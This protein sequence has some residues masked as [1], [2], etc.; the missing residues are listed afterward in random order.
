MII[1]SII[2]EI[3]REYESEFVH[4]YELDSGVEQCVADTMNQLVKKD[5]Q[6]AIGKAYFRTEYVTNNKCLSE[7]TIIN[8][9]G[10]VRAAFSS[11]EKIKDDKMKG[12]PLGIM[13]HEPVSGNPRPDHIIKRF[14]KNPDEVM[15][16]YRDAEKN[17]KEVFGLSSESEVKEKAREI[18]GTYKINYKED[19]KKL[20]CAKAYFRAKDAKES[21]SI[22][23]HFV[24]DGET[25]GI[26]NIAPVTIKTNHCAGAFNQ[27]HIA[28]EICEPKRIM[29]GKTDI[30]TL[31]EEE[32]NSKRADCLRSFN[33]AVL[34]SALLCIKFSMDSMGKDTCIEGKN[35][36]YYSTILSHRE[37]HVYFAEASNHGD[38]EAL[39][40]LL[41]Q[42]EEPECSMDK[43]RKKVKE[44]MALLKTLGISEEHIEPPSL[45]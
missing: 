7:P 32:L 44:T 28:I 41:W 23:I 38:P 19:K 39:W 43:F 3:L 25:G 18:R 22:A 40:K 35:K 20:D 13:L 45:P 42:N 10:L 11:Q 2:E 17:F 26:V 15:K 14:N 21:L 33:S 1:K 16:K 9:E 12:V 6:A 27:T 34:L 24:I 8:K 36:E 31:S 4:C 5:I 29:P 30:K 37:G